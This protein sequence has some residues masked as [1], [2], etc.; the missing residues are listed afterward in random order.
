MSIFNIPIPGCSE[1]ANEETEVIETVL[2][3][4]ESTGKTEAAELYKKLMQYLLSADQACQDNVDN[5]MIKIGDA[6]QAKMNL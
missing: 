1:I 2:I 3:H 5:V 4:E 6:L